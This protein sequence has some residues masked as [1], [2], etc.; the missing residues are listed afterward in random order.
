MLREQGLEAELVQGTVERLQFR[1]AAFDLVT[2]VMVFHHLTHPEAGVRELHRITKP[3]GCIVLVDWA[4]TAAR[5]PFPPGTH[6]RHDF[7]P[8]A[9]ARRLF[10][11]EPWRVVLRSRRLWYVLRAERKAKSATV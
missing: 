7:L 4:P 2:S 5:L 9:R 1:D 11:M 8:A 6:H 3:G 10:A